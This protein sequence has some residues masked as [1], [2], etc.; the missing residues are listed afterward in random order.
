MSRT[1]LIG[2]F[3]ACNNDSNTRNYLYREFSEYYPW[4]KQSQKWT[5]RQ[6]K[7]VINHVNSAN[8]KEGERFYLK[9]L[10]NHVRGLIFFLKIY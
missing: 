6:N 3:E 8:P 10:L 1:M 4:N 2:N 9:L 7:T 5:K